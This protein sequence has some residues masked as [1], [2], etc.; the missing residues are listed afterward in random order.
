[1][2]YLRHKTI[3]IIKRK[4]TQAA[5]IRRTPTKM[6]LVKVKYWHQSI[7][8]KKTPAS[9]VYKLYNVNG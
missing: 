2:F 1:M 7:A 6:V 5:F 8:N 9:E 4:V 3:Q